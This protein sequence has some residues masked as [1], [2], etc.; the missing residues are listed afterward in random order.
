MK[1]T[2]KS[3]NKIFMIDGEKFKKWYDK[4]QCLAAVKQTWY[5]LQYVKDQTEQICLAAVEQNGDALRY[6]NIHADYIEIQDG[7]E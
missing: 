2:F 5:A 1:I 4:K 6:V 3:S 7:E